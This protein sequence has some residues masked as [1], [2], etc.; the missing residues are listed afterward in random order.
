MVGIRSAVIAVNSLVLLALLI[1]LSSSLHQFWQKRHNYPIRAR[2]PFHATF[3]I[4]FASTFLALSSIFIALTDYKLHCLVW[5]VLNYV[6]GINAGLIAFGCRIFDFCLSYEVELLKLKLCKTSENT[7]SNNRDVKNNNGRDSRSI[8]ISSTLKFMDIGKVLSKR[9]QFKKIALACYF[10]A[11]FPFIIGIATYPSTWNSQSDYF[12]DVCYSFAFLTGSGCVFVSLMLV[13]FVL[14]LSRSLRSAQDNYFIKEELKRYC[15]LL[16]IL[17]V[18]W[19]ANQVVPGLRTFSY[20]TIGFMDILILQFPAFWICYTSIYDVM[21]REIVIP[22]RK[23]LMRNNS[24]MKG[25]SITE[26]ITK[27]S[28]KMSSPPQDDLERIMDDP[29][30]LQKFTDFLCKEF[31]VEELLFLI[32]ARQFRTDF[33]IKTRAENVKAGVEL[34]QKFIREDSTLAVNVSGRTR[35]HL[36]ECF[37]KSDQIL[38]EDLKLDGSIVVSNKIFDGAYSEV[39][40]MLSIDCLRRFKRQALQGVAPGG[41]PSAGGLQKK[42]STSSPA[43]PS[44]IIPSAGM[45]WQK[46]PDLA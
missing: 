9:S 43:T 46:R 32:A 5:G 23:A 18:F 29:E 3:A 36:R 45:F 8:F 31:C 15:W 40:L 35:D 26:E 20:D 21:K 16:A 13:C 11:N 14:I 2:A 44:Q 4:V 19:L 30:L 41:S 17:I 22:S 27:G 6:F 33:H 12:S 39:V 1:F 28:R 42:L 7:N 34:Y 10:G 37:G 38:H 25:N 24:S